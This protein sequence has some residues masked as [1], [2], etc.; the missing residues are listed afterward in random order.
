MKIF[1]NPLI[2]C[3]FLCVLSKDDIVFHHKP[4]F[5]WVNR[6]LTKDTH[7]ILAKNTT[8][9]LIIYSKNMATWY[10]IVNKIMNELVI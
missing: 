3:I 6:I 5:G 9:H 4:R 10:I 2:N 8:I 7:R 1:K